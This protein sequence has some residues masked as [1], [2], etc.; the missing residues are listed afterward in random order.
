MKPLTVEEIE[1]IRHTGAAWLGEETFERLMVTLDTNLLGRCAAFLEALAGTCAPIPARVR[2]EFDALRTE[3][4]LYR[5][6]E[7]P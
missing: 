5:D 7:V 2:D 3:F 4:A 6:R 1:A